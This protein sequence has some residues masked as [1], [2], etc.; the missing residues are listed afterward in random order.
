MDPNM[1]IDNQLVKM[2]RDWEENR[3][4]DIL[5][6]YDYSNDRLAQ[7]VIELEDLVYTR[8]SEKD[9]SRQQLREAVSLNTHLSHEITKRDKKIKEYH[10]RL[11][12]VRVRS[13]INRIFSKLGYTQKEDQMWKQ[14]DRRRFSLD[15][16]FKMTLTFYMWVTGVWTITTLVWF[17]MNGFCFF[18][19]K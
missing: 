18:L 19:A 8:E 14:S 5:K 11:I 3:L 10:N 15:K 6:E 2:E 17:L 7:R 13:F 1:G 16:L 12:K 4:N 9:I